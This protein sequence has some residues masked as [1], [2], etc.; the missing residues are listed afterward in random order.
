MPLA[1]QILMNVT[2]L[3]AKCPMADCV[4]RAVL[5]PLLDGAQQ[6]R[7]VHRSVAAVRHNSTDSQPYGSSS[8]RCSTA[9]RAAERAATATMSTN[10]GGAVSLLLSACNCG[11]LQLTALVTSALQ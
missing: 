2:M 11:S 1:A 5:R 4:H 9:Y 3:V 10:A 8:L 7:A 6:Q